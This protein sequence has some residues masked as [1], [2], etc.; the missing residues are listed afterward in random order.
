MASITVILQ[1]LCQ[2]LSPIGINRLLQS[3]SPCSYSIDL[4][5]SRSGRYL[6]TNGE[7]AIIRPWFWILCIFCGPFFR[8]LAFQWFIFIM[9]RTIARTE[10]ILTQLV[11]EHSLRMRFKAETS[12]RKDEQIESGHDRDST[13][14]GTPDTASLA[15]SDTGTSVSTEGAAS[16]S[17]S[18]V[19]GQSS[20]STKGKSKRGDATGGKGEKGSKDD[21]NIL[22]KINNLVTSDL[23]NITDGREFIVLCERKLPFNFQLFQTDM[24]SVVSIPL[25]IVVAVFFLYQILGWRS[26]FSV[27]PDATVPST[28]I[29]YFSAFA[30]L[31][32]MVA[33]FPLPGYV[34]KLIQETQRLRMKKVQK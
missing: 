17:E 13:T 20:I 18:T 15:E 2:F 22:G 30:G 26:D 25:Q 21:E 29:V 6:E 32:T 5:S 11:F 14:L 7:N 12:S 10:G 33:L 27:S 9:T 19:A 16:A 34:A 1:G 28:Q 8:S 3:V 4:Y 23:N 31:G 24:L